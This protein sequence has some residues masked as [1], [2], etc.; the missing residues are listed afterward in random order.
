MIKALLVLGTTLYPSLALGAVTCTK[1]ENGIE[2]VELGSVPDE[3]REEKP[4]CKDYR[5]TRICIA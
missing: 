5:G 1:T 2:C 4:Q 3:S